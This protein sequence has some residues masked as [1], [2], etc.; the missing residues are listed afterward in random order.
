MDSGGFG[1]YS[2]LERVGCGDLIWKIRDAVHDF[3]IS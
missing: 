2:I 3:W 1:L